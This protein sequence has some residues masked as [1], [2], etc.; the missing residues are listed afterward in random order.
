MRPF[1]PPISYPYFSLPRD[2]VVE[3][4]APAMGAKGL[5]IPFDQPG[6]IT[7]DILCVHPDCGK[8]ARYFTLFGRSY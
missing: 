2:V 7:P 8:A 5:C 4:G 1:L 6:E 3:E